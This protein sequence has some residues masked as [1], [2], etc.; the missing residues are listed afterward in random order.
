MCVETI[1]NGKP[2]QVILH[3]RADTFYIAKEHVDEV[4]LS[5]IKEKV[6]LLIEWARTGPGPFGPIGGPLNGKF[7]SSVRS[8]VGP[9]GPETGPWTVN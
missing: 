3:I 6:G 9:A 4:G 8:R 2:L 7:R 5:Y 1:I